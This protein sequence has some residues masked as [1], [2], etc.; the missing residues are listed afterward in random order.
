MGMM[1]QCRCTKKI[2]YGADWSKAVTSDSTIKKK[3]CLFK[4]SY[5]FPPHNCT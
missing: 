4:L 1:E 3:N 5:T 2:Q